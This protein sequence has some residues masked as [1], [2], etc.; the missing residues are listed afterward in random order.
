MSERD[1]IPKLSADGKFYCSP[2]CGSG[3][4]C[5]KEWHDE[6]VRKAGELAAQLGD[7]WEPHVFENLGWHCKVKKGCASVWPA[8]DGFL[9]R[10]EPGVVIG[11][12]ALQFI[13]E[14]ETPEDALGFAVQ[15]A[16]TTMSRV[17]DALAI[18]NDVLVP[19]VAP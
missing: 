8:R 11:H 19:E 4:Y 6:A 2:A 16:R 14:G 17:N 15:D 3:H 12:A 5:R 13:A 7:G 10:I 1:W 18:V 9:A